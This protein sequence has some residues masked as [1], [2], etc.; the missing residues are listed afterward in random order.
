MRYDGSGGG[1]G[2]GEGPSAPEY[3]EPGATIDFALSEG[4]VP[5]ASP[6]TLDILT[7]EGDLVR[8]FVGTTGDTDDA[9]ASPER[10]MGQL[11][12][13]A[14]SIDT[15]AVHSGHNRFRWNLRYPGPAPP[16][17]G[18]GPL[19]VPG[20][21]KVRLSVGDWTQTRSFALKMDPRLQKT[22]T[23]RA[24][25]EEQFFFNRRLQG[26]I[27]EAEATAHAIDSMRTDVQAAHDAGE[28]PESEAKPLLSRLDELHGTLVTSEEG[29][30]Q[31]PMLID[32]LGYLAWMTGSADQELG[33]DAFS[34]FE[35][36]RTR[37]DRIQQQWR[38]LRADIEVPTTD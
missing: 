36:L 26:A 21:Y 27:E 22:G 37:L 28:M 38:S 5:S 19:A 24:D 13:P 6:L 30:Y 8:R 3:P 9:S 18:S 17:D 34:R 2:R 14:S 10:R 29:S 1:Y 16:A 35:T 4:Q 23:T 15:F 20:T 25:L 7:Q 11:P 32:Q 33:E 12:I 31:P